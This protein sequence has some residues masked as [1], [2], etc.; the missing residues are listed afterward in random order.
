MKSVKKNLVLRVSSSQE[1]TPPLDFVPPSRPP[2]SGERLGALQGGD[3][4]LEPLL[5]GLEGPLRP[6]TPFRRSLR[7]DRKKITKGWSG[8]ILIGPGRR[9]SRQR[10]VFRNWSMGEGF[11]WLWDCKKIYNGGEAAPLL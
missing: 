3:V 4:L 2:P 7:S 6:Q 10:N 8:T 9:F 5:E 11:L 1:R